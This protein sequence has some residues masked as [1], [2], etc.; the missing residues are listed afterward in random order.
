MEAVFKQRAII[1]STSPYDFI[2]EDRRTMSGVSVE[3]ILTDN[4]VPRAEGAMKGI[5]TGKDS[6][7][8]D[9]QSKFVSVPAMYELTFALRAGQKGKMQL[10]LADADFIAEVTLVVGQPGA[11]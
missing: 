6:L 11:V 1:L 9:K 10:K 5:K 2:A 7:P 8:L 4:L 3:Y